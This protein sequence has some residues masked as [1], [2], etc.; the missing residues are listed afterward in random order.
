MTLVVCA[1]TLYNTHELARVTRLAKLEDIM[2]DK[3][4]EERFCS[5]KFQHNELS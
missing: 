2:A 1:A 4:A 3:L 5:N